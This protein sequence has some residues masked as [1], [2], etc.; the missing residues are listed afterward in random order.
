[1]KFELG[2]QA[3]IKASSEQGEVIGRA[4]YL[5][6]ENAY[7]LRYKSGDGRA[8]EAWWSASALQHA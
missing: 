3:Q 1:M 4:E 6:T 2:Q 7:L 8:V 5:N